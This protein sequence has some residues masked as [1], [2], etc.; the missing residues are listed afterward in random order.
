VLSRA[1]EGVDVDEPAYASLVRQD[2]RIRTR[3][4]AKNFE[5]RFA[6]RPDS[7]ET[8]LGHSPSPN[9]YSTGHVV[10]DPT[11]NIRSVKAE[12]VKNAEKGGEKDVLE[13]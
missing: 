11:V 1:S 8:R 9:G 2:G 6:P 7:V 10:T 5:L 12:T 3:I 4:V 13:T